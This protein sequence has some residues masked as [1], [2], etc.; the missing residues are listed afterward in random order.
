MA[1]DTFS[2]L[3]LARQSHKVVLPAPIASTT[4]SLTIGEVAKPDTDVG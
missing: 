1:S 2:K 4:T 3:Q